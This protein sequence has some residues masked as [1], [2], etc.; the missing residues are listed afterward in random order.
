M[1]LCAT[2]VANTLL[3]TPFLDEVVYSALSG[4]KD[5]KIVHE[6][7]L[8]YLKEVEDNDK[9][10]LGNVY[11]TGGQDVKMKEAEVNAAAYFRG[12]RGEP[13]KIDTE[14]KKPWNCAFD[15]NAKRPCIS[16]NLKQDHPPSALDANGRCKFKHVCDAFIKGEDGKRTTCGA[17]GHCRK[18]C[19]NP[20]R[21]SLVG[22]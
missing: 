5:W 3:V 1:I 19:N 13:A 22:A 9:Y 11:A 6:L 8:I 16:F 10:N 7:F 18:D 15:A 2:G 20:A 12:Q 17:A 4:G 21:E 14:V